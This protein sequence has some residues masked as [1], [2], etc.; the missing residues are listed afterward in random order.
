M[1]RNYL[2]EKGPSHFMKNKIKTL[3]K[4]L[5]FF[6]IW[7][8]LVVIT[9]R[10]F[11]PYI[12][13]DFIGKSNGTM[14]LYNEIVSLLATII[15]TCVLIFVVDRKS[16][17]KIFKFDTIGIDTL[18]GM[19]LGLG[20][21]ALIIGILYG[22]K[23]VSLDIK[24]GSFNLEL[25]IWIISLLIHCIMIH[26]LVRGYIYRIIEKE[27]SELSAIMMTGII[28]TLVHIKYYGLDILTIFN[29]FTLGIIFSFTLSLFKSLWS[30]IIMDFSYTVILGIGTGLIKFTS[31][32]PVC[33]SSSVSNYKFFSFG[34]YGLLSGILITI[35][36]LSLIILLMLLKIKNNASSKK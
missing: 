19:G 28:F 34:T 23:S 3:G 29:I 12:L 14:Q 15:A 16:K 7:I 21:S 26:L 17:I 33:I 18:I 31:N 2:I 9:E 20:Y 8:V 1:I 27:Q 25:V 30:V 4:C 32:Y 22:M 11:K 24:N 13:V 10:F 6:I 35:I 5:L 36:N